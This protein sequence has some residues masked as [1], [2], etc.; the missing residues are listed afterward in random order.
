MFT[1]P[2]IVI[3][4]LNF[5]NTAFK[6]KSLISLTLL[7]SDDWIHSECKTKNH[8]KEAQRAPDSKQNLSCFLLFCMC[9]YSLTWQLPLGPVRIPVYLEII[10]ER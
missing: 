7:Y 6:A 3:L 2:Q 1:S 8:A 9:T 4:A 5:T 10:G